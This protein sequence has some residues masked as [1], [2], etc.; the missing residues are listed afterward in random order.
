ME[1]LLF[2]LRRRHNFLQLPAAHSPHCELARETDCSRW[3]AMPLLPSASASGCQTN[4]APQPCT[5]QA[6]RVWHC[7]V[8]LLFWRFPFYFDHWCACLGPCWCGVARF[9][10]FPFY[11]DLFCQVL[12]G[13]WHGSFS[14]SLL[15]I[16]V[17]FVQLVDF[18]R[19]CSSK[20]CRK[21]AA[22][23]HAGASSTANSKN[24]N[25]ASRAINHC[26]NIQPRTS[27]QTTAH[28]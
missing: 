18:S 10:H 26:G 9:G 27:W 20:G 24:A 11:F 7:S 2:E 19:H 14:T 1:A 4:R 22:T 8:L 6:Q 12:V 5:L 17:N 3:E 21:T 13:R 28:T 23:W 25:V 16:F 15:L